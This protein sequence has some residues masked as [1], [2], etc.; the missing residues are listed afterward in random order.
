MSQPGESAVS[1]TLVPKLVLGLMVV[2]C[3]L[4]GYILFGLSVDHQPLPAPGGGTTPATHTYPERVALSWLA[5]FSAAGAGVALFLLLRR[6]LAPARWVWVLLT[7][8]TMV[9]LNAALLMSALPTPT[10]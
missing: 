1:P 10:Y 4:A 9:V 2:A 3:A 7:A 6:G 5:W 8:A